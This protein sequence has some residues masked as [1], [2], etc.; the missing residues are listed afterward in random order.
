[1]RGWHSVIDYAS[2][3]SIHNG[4]LVYERRSNLLCEKRRSVAIGITKTTKMAVCQKN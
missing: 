4:C 1:M 2:P 3:L